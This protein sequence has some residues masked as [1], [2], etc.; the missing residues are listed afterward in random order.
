[1]R[2]FEVI[3]KVALG[4]EFFWEKDGQEITSVV[5]ERNVTTLPSVKVMTLFRC[6]V[7]WP[8]WL[9]MKSSRLLSSCECANLGDFAAK[10]AVIRSP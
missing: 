8:A 4:V 1:M 3:D 10:D 9:M 6:A 2:D 5:F 7:A